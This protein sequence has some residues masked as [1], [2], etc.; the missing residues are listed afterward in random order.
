MLWEICSGIIKFNSKKEI[1][2]FEYNIYVSFGIFLSFIIH[3]LPINFSDFDKELCFLYLQ[4]LLFS[5]Q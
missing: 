4:Q 3:M 2:L 1:V 5:A